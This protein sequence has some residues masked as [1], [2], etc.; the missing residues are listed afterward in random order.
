MKLLKNY[1]RGKESGADC[2]KFQS[3]QDTIFSKKYQDNFNLEEI[4]E[5]YSISEK[6]LLEMK[7]V[8]N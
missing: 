7:K 3:W 1:S 5:A 8:N 4:V 2:V 6:E